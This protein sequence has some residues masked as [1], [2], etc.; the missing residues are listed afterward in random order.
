MPLT[1]DEIKAAYAVD[2]PTFEFVLSGGEKLKAKTLTDA[3]ALLDMEKKSKTFIKLAQFSP[4]DEWKPFL[5]ANENILKMSVFV[6]EL[7]V[8]PQMSLVECLD[9][10][11]NCG[12]MFMDL[13]A[14]VM[15]KTSN[16]ITAITVEA[17]EE[18]KNE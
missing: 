3:S 5:P 12:I 18:A 2:D 17:L 4:L 7:M 11:K 16:Q 6:S 1:F 10:A 8:E 13:A 14:K 15:E 9:L